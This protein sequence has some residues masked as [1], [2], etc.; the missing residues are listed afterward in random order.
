MEKEQED[1]EQEE[2]E[3]EEK[4]PGEKERIK[5]V[6]L[7][8]EKVK[9][10]AESEEKAVWQIVLYLPI[11][12]GNPLDK[13]DFNEFN[14]ICYTRPFQAPAVNHGLD[15]TAAPPTTSFFMF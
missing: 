11:V 12:V 10:Q 6:T 8:K 14:S 1:K 7:V 13:S 3:L 4:E 2:K 15:T 5:A 9:V